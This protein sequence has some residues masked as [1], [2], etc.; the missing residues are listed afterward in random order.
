VAINE[1]YFNEALKD[2]ES[3]LY[4]L[5]KV[6]S[7]N[8]GVAGYFLYGFG[9]LFILS[10]LKFY[11]SHISG[12]LFYHLPFWLQV[13]GM[14][15]VYP[16]VFGLPLWLMY[17]LRNSRVK[18]VWHS[19]LML[20]YLKDKS[21]RKILKQFKDSEKDPNEKW[22]NK[23]IIPS[24]LS[25]FHSF[26][27]TVILIYSVTILCL[28]AL[29]ASFY[30]TSEASL[31]D[32]TTMYSELMDIEFLNIKVIK[33]KYEFTERTDAM[34]IENYV[35][36]CGEYYCETFGD[37]ILDENFN[38]IDLS[39]YFG[40]EEEIYGIVFYNDNIAVIQYGIQEGD[41]QAF[42]VIDIDSE[43]I[44]YII[45]DEDIDLDVEFYYFKD[46]FYRDNY[47]YLAGTEHR[48]D[49]DKVAAIYKFDETGIVDV[50]YSDNGKIVTE[51]EMNGDSIFISELSKDNNGTTILKELNFELDIIQ[52]I[53]IEDFALYNMYNV[54]GNIIVYDG[55]FTYDYY[56]VNEDL[57]L[58]F[59]FT[60]IS[61]YTWI[62]HFKETLSYG[63]TLKT[64]TEFDKDLNIVNEG[65]QC[66][67]CTDDEYFNDYYFIRK[68]NKVYAID[69]DYTL[70]FTEI[71]EDKYSLSRSSL[72]IIGIV[73]YLVVFL[74]P[75]TIFHIILRRREKETM[76]V[77]LH[78]EK[79]KVIQ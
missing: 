6:L 32:M 22:W 61:D 35:D 19:M 28:G 27:K 39:I 56:L 44:L 46:G 49:N 12:Y 51:I 40:T 63:I 23:R 20:H 58:D 54:D 14:V 31:N 53:L 11:P 52:E 65:L 77:E 71:D 55:N 74:I 34:L 72:T 79:L 25:P 70:V 66:D 41:Y 38:N 26:S 24:K 30:M 18:T 37:F 21:Y 75:I 17:R 48:S 8:R 64:Y 7:F 9:Y 59:K 13:I 43:T 33:T 47:V 5:E 73:V 45:D 62:S 42:K 4:E 29:I 69:E 76:K 3:A 68:D 10:M 36:S 15:V 78:L 1:E 67:D 16:I 60:R 57:T 50:Y 2:N